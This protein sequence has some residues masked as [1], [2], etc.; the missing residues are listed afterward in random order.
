MKVTPGLR[1]KTTVVIME[2]IIKLAFIYK[3][4]KADLNT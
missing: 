3:I 2:V 4:Y 1:I